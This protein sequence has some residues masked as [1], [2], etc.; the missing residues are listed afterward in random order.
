MYRDQNQR[1]FARALR[2]QPTPAE[3]RLR[4]FLKAGNLGVKFRRQARAPSVADGRGA[5]IV[6]FVC[7]SHKL[8]IELDGPQHLTP[9]SLEYDGRRMNWLASEGFHIMR[10]RNQELDDNIHGVVDTVA[11]ALQG[12]VPPRNHPSPNPSPQGGGGQSRM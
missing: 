2:N 9:E 12:A 5:Y 8:I 1:D 4:Y 3:Q 6:D 10:F 7:F 11:R